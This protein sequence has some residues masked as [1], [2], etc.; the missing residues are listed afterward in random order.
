MSE[1][2][3]GTHLICATRCNH[4]RD[5]PNL[6]I[7][8]APISAA[9]DLTVRV[10][11]PGQLLRCSPQAHKSAPPPR[12]STSIAFTDLAS[13]SPPVRTWSP[14]NPQTRD[15]RLDATMWY[16]VLLFFLPLLTPHQPVH[17][18]TAMKN[19]IPLEKFCTCVEL[20]K[21]CILAGIFAMVRSPFR[22]I[23][24]NCLPTLNKYHTDLFCELQCNLFFLNIA[25]LKLIYK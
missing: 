10:V 3:M 8:I 1:C 25:I 7:A 20:W 16:L 4:Q 19:A 15:T 9:I 11:G 23:S 6:I 5:G 24:I 18:S 2:C 21:G 17:P 12:A 22:F 14:L 13:C